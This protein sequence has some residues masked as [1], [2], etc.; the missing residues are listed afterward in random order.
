MDVHQWDALND[1]LQKRLL[2]KKPIPP[3]L[4]KIMAHGLKPK[5]MDRAEEE[6][7]TREAQRIIE[8][9]SFIA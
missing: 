4:H 8:R 5:S 1:I 2:L 7:Q 6:N 9:E 3:D